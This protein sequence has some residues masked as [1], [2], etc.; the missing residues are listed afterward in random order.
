M[1]IG[2]RAAQ[3]Q[4]F[5]YCR[6]LYLAKIETVTPDQESSFHQRWQVL[7][8]RIIT[9]NGTDVGWLQS[10]AQDDALFLVQLF[11]ETAAQG[12]GIG[13]ETLKRLIKEAAEARVPMTLCV[14]K[15]NPAQR[16]YERL[17]FKKIHE[18]DRK[19]Y[20]KYEPEEDRPH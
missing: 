16:L 4:D 10:R 7:E 11:L 2:F 12:K 20:M 19:F 3:I 8:V 13:T 14:V 17:G 5:D 15:S 1:R 9:C 18:D 6:S